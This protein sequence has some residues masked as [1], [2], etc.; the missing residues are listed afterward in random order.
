MECICYN[1]TLNLAGNDFMK[2][3]NG[4]AIKKK[5]RKNI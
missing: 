4:V 5:K 3:I 1:L 2:M